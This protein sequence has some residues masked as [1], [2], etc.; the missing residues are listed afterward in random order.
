M[1]GSPRRLLCSAWRLTLRMSCMPSL[2]GSAFAGTRSAINY[3]PRS[4]QDGTAAGGHAGREPVLNSNWQLRNRTD[5]AGWVLLINN[6]LVVAQPCMD[7][8]FEAVRVG[9]YAAQGHGDLVG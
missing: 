1:A 4:G 5:R 7:G 3:G 6:S 2:R 8:E 9:A